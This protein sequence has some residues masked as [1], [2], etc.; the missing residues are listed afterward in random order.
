[1][2]NESLQSR[3]EIG[4]LPRPAIAPPLPSPPLPSPPL[5]SPPLPSPPTYSLLQPTTDGTYYLL[6][7]AWKGP[8]EGVDILYC[9][10]V[11]ADI[12]RFDFNKGLLVLY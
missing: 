6:R 2:K 10:T 7:S 8:P 3:L 9:N 12:I 5:P 1:M 4:I 11:V